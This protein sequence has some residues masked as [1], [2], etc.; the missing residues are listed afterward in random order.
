MTLRNLIRPK[1]AAAAEK[2]AADNHLQLPENFA[3]R[4]DYT[5]ELK[6]GH[7]ATP[8]AMELA[9]AFRLPPRA[10]AEKIIAVMDKEFF[11]KVELAGAGFINFTLK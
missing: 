5:P 11:A 7:Y 2:V 1:V 8:A 9:K 3:P 4:I 6:F 10:I